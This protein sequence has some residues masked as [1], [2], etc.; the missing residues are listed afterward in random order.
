[1]NRSSLLV[2]ALSLAA[3]AAHADDAD[4]SG[5]FAASAAGTATRAEIQAQLANY[6]QA[7]VNPWS[8]SYNPLKSFQSTRTR[9]EVQAEY[10]ASRDA[11]AAMTREDSGSAYLAARPVTT[12]VRYLAGTPAN[13]Q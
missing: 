12:D 11:V 1:M 2:A 4:P 9:A 3:F 7:G 13:A 5:Q 6:K 10:L 8:T